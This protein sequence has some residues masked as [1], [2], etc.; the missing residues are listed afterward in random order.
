MVEDGPN[1]WMIDG[2]IQFHEYGGR[3]IGGA[4]DYIVDPDYQC[5]MEVFSQVDGVATREDRFRLTVTE[6]VVVTGKEC[7]LSELGGMRWEENTYR[8]AFE[9][10]E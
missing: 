3:L 5:S 6:Q 10:A 7:D 8:L 1:G 2:F 4:E 9:P